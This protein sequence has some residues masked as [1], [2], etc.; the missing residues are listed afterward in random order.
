MRQ[1]HAAR[2]HLREGALELTVTA[3]ACGF[4]HL[5]YF[6]QDYRALFGEY[7]SETLEN[8]KGLFPSGAH[9]G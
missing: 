5:I 6:S 1:L 4:D 8:S 9:W 2:R 7:P 3:L